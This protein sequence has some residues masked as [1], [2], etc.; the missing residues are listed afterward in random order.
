MSFER[1][2]E[3]LYE[4]GPKVPVSELWNLAKQD[5][6]EMAY[7]LKTIENKEGYHILR[8]FLS[9]NKVNSFFRKAALQKFWGEVLYPLAMAF[10]DSE[11]PH[12]E[13]KIHQGAR[14]NGRR[15]RR[16]TVTGFEFVLHLD[17]TANIRVCYSAS[18]GLKLEVRCYDVAVIHLSRDYKGKH[19]MG[20]Y[21]SL[22]TQD[23]HAEAVQRALVSVEKFHKAA[24]KIHDIYKDKIEEGAAL[25]EIKNFNVLVGKRVFSHRRNTSPRYR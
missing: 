1:I 23:Y 22:T 3:E 20:H 24:C 15:L 17:D 18:Y 21:Q 8:N 2:R 4:E 9:C 11:M 12:H 14:F 10:P 25:I 13:V 5:P 6:M 16:T 19:Y 7:F